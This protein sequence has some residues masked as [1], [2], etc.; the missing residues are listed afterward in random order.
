MVDTDA[1]LDFQNEARLQFKQIDDLKLADFEITAK[2]RDSVQSPAY[3]FSY[4]MSLAGERYVYGRM[5]P[6]CA[7]ILDWPR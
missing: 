7:N 3:K 4:Q 1:D 6:I 2:V 5:R